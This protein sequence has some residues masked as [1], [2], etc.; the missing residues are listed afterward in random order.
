ML[1]HPLQC[2]ETNAEGTDGTS[3]RGVAG[4]T[5]EEGRNK[6]YLPDRKLKNTDV[7]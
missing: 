1:I 5:T 3:G 6:V 2:I 7:S 4:A